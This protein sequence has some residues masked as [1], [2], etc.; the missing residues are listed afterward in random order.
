MSLAYIAVSLDSTGFFEYAA[1]RII[2]R[3]GGSGRKLFIYF[4]LLSS[5]ITLFTSN[6]IVILTLTPIIFYFGKHARM[7]VIPLLIAEFF[8]ANIW[9]MFLLVGNPTNIIVG[10]AHGI[11]YLE[12]AYWM[13]LPTVSGGLTCLGILFL[14]FRKAINVRFTV[15]RDTDPG[16]FIKDRTSMLVALSVFI[17]SM[18]SMAAS[19]LIGLELWQIAAVAASVLLAYDAGVAFREFSNSELVFFHAFKRFAYHKETHI[20]QF[21]LHMIAERLPWKVVPFLLCSFV[22]VQ[23]LVLTGFTDWAASFIASLSG[24]ILAAA[25]SMGFLSSFAANVMNNQPMTVLFT[26]ITES[27]G[28]A[29]AEP[30]RTA[31]IYSLIIGSNLGANIT[32]VGALAGIMWLKILNSK[33]HPVRPGDFARLGLLVTPWVILASCAALAI[34]LILFA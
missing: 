21:R 32:V 6:D 23:S 13:L 17:A 4:Y 5:V 24:N 31:S 34:E 9:S 15:H 29:L 2:Q 1:I 11:S 7:N 3:S 19:P 10:L 18:V 16:M 26:R 22:M 28:F 27:P 30:A 8:A 12:Y 33:E 14:L 20:Y 25:L